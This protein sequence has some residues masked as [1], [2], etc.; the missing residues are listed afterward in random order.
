V[1]EAIERLD[2][3]REHGPAPRAFTFKR[4]FSP[5]EAE[6]ASPDDWLCPA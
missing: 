5:G 1:K 3:L 2:H 4:R 6:L